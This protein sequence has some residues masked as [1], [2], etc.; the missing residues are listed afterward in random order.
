MA[1]LPCLGKSWEYRRN[2]SFPGGSTDELGSVP[3]CA[4]Q[5]R[6]IDNVC[7]IRTAAHPDERLNAK[8]I[9]K[10]EAAS[11]KLRDKEFRRALELL[12]RSEL[13]LGDDDKNL[14]DKAAPVTG[15]GP[16]IGKAAAIVFAK[17]RVGALPRIRCVEPKHWNARLD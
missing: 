10:T 1:I 4:V 2:Q 7:D 16:G 9:P 5:Q 3:T 13:F 6:H 15:A 8:I 17:A 12:F 11:A 14:N